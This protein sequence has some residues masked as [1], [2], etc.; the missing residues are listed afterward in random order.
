MI[1]SFREVEGQDFYY[2]LVRSYGNEIR[3]RIKCI[4]DT[5]ALTLGNMKLP[6]NY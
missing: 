5:T 3:H 1:L 2:S 6:V 4:L